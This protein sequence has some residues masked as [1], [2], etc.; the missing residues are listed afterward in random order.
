MRWVVF[1]GSTSF[2]WLVFFFGALLWGPW[3]TSI[4]EDGCDKGAHQL[5][6]GAERNTLVNPNWFQPCQYCCCL[7]YPGEYLSPGI[8]SLWPSK[9]SVHSLWSLCWCHRCCLSWAWSSQHWSPC[10]RLWRFCQDAQLNVPVLLPLLLT[11]KCQTMCTMYHHTVP[12]QWQC[13]KFSPGLLCLQ[14]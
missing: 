3:F 7:C 12:R 10:P 1:C 13:P 14:T 5:Y 8:W 4:Q 11:W 6:L 2:P 9:A